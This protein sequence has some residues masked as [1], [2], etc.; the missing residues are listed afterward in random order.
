MLPS[1]KAVVLPISRANASPTHQPQRQGDQHEE[2]PLY[3]VHQQHL[4]HAGAPATQHGHLS[5]TRPHSIR[6]DHNK[7]DAHKRDNR[8]G[9]HGQDQHERIGRG[10]VLAQR[11]RRR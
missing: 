10:A 4:L 8:R 11:V 2:Q 5:T 9:E 3:Q 1:A 7:K 6:R